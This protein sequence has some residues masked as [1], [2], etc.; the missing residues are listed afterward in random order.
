MFY[1][2]DIN[3][4]H[5]YLQLAFHHISDMVFLIH[6]DENGRFRYST[7]NH[8]A[9]E[10]FS[11]PD[12]FQ[13]R[14]ISEIM[15]HS[16]ACI[17]QKKYQEAMEQQQ[18]I[19]YQ[20]RIETPSG[21]SGESP[22]TLDVESKVT[23]IIDECGRCD[24]L[25]AVTRD[26]TSWVEQNKQF[27]QALQQVELMFNHTAD[28]VFMFDKDARY[29]KVNQGFTNILGWTEEEL[30]RDSSISILPAEDSGFP[31][32]WHQLQQGHVIENH[33]DRRIAK[34]GR[35][36]NVLASYSPVMEDGKMTGGVA[37][38]KDITELKQVENRLRESEEKYR[39]IV[40]HTN[41]LIRVLDAEGFVQYASPSHKD[42]L[43]LPSDFFVGKSILSF[44]HPDDM[45]KLQNTI[46]E[47]LE[48]GRSADI[49]YR[50]YHKA[51]TII[52]IEAQCTPVLKHNGTV[53]QIV[54]VARDVSNRK[55]R[56]EKLRS[57]AMYDDLTGLPN[58]RFFYQELEQ[59]VKVTQRYISSYKS[60]P[61]LLTLDCD[62][63]KAINDTHGHDIGDKVIKRFAERVQQCLR[64]ADLFSRVGGDEFLILLPNAEKEADVTMIARRILHAL[65]EPLPI[66]NNLLT[67]TTSIGAAFYKKENSVEQWVRESD[68]ALYK[69]KTSGEDSFRFY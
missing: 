22:R 12:N 47:I 26:V 44:T 59:T 60:R 52:W 20:S 1:D 67:L 58:R 18:T 17:I 21:D 28:A 42:V 64:D 33:Y 16:S 61:A 38:Y 3:A 7:A 39:A 4:H 30:L 6:R 32:I 8:K 11:F 29:T 34:S 68:K 9:V 55:S 35:I 50:R 23:P 41:D 2:S 66:E 43:G 31:S 63:F 40:N 36:V 25:I 48:T 10:M 5:N 69:A 27:K 57:M 46:N 14:E 45:D 56:E 54:L 62:N 24:Y 49:E 19:T 65:E 15:P 51:G 53:E 13:G 37:M